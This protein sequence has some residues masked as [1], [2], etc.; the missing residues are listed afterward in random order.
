MTEPARQAGRLGRLPNNPAKPRLRV[1][2][3]TV[4][5]P[6]PPPSADWYSRV[7]SWPMYLNDQLGDC[8]CAEVGHQIQS[9]SAYG[10]GS[11]VAVSDN[12]VEALYELAGGYVPGQSSTDNGAVI[13]DV[14]GDWQKTGCG[15][16]KCVAFAEVDVTNHAEVQAAIADFGSVDIGFTVY[17]GDMDAFNAGQEW[18]ASYPEGP[19][20]GGHSVEV[21][22]YDANGLMIV[23]WGALQ[24]ATWAWWNSRVDEAWLVI[25]PEWLSAG[26]TSASGLDL[27]QL[28]E[29][30]AALTG[31][32]NPIP[33][34]PP[35]VQPPSAADVALWEGE[36][37]AWC[38]AFRERPDLVRLKSA[39]EAWAA[40]H[41]LT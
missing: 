10:E 6:A 36:A 41:G 35:V 15:G 12:D 32:P 25:Q 31:Q 26:G 7:A 11:T 27:Y 18:S 8:T 39:L 37:K 23:T 40:A 17:Q 14:L 29:A 5:P 2:D 4:T 30:L 13:Q 9:A 1:R 33:A 38:A 20:L 28:G 3:Y 34:P 22:G 19:V 16:R 21:A 24:K